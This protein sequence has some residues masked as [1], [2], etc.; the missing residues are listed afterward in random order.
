MRLYKMATNKDNEKNDKPGET[1]TGGKSKEV[2]KELRSDYDWR[3][4]VAEGYEEW[5]AKGQYTHFVTINYNIWRSSTSGKKVY[6]NKTNSFTD[7]GGYRAYNQDDGRKVFQNIRDNKRIGERGNDEYWKASGRTIWEAQ[8]KMEH[9]KNMI[10]KWDTNINQYMFGTDFYRKEKWKG[11]TLSFMLFAENIHSN[12]HYH[13]VTNIEDTAKYPN[14]VDRFLEMAN[15]VWY[16]PPRKK[17]FVDEDGNKV[18]DAEADYKQSD[19][20]KE[21]VCPG[22]Q[23]WIEKIKT[24]EDQDRIAGYVTK[25]MKYYGNEEGMYLTNDWRK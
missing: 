17:H 7:G 1:N 24:D 13:G 4:L 22:G 14:K 20:Q 21:S 9:G 8:R 6:D 16:S 5:I 19:Y 11:E 18:L 3:N 25:Q 2:S 15:E 10:R 12:L 23:I